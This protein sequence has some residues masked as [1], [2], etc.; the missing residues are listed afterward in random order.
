MRST[1]FAPPIPGCALS[2]RFHCAGA[3]ERIRAAHYLARRE[4]AYS[5]PVVFVAGDSVGGVIIWQGA[6]ERRAFPRY[7]Q[8]RVDSFCF[9]HFRGEPA[10]F[11]GVVSTYWPGLESRPFGNK[12]HYRISSEVFCSCTGAVI[13][14]GKINGSH[15]GTRTRY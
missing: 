13:T 2:R 14:E 11:L 7:P 15:F 4:R 3:L 5:A 1:I 6:A 8:Q 12:S 10:D 9:H